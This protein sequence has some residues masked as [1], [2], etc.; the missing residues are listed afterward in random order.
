VLGGRTSANDLARLADLA[1]E[2]GSGRIRTTNTQSI[3]LLD[4][5]EANLAPLRDELN[6]ARFNY[7][8]SWSRRGIIAC[9][10]IQFCKLAVAE[11]KNRAAELNDYLENSVALDG[12]VRISV[13]GCPNSCGQH[14]ICDVGL[15]GS[16]TT[17]NGVKRETF[18]VFLGGGVG[19]RETFGRRVGVRIPSE[20][21][22]ESIAR[23][24]THYRQAREE[25]ETFQDFC[26]RHSDKELAEYLAPPASPARQVE[27]SF[28][29][30]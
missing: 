28:A 24:L 10:G 23:L 25:G 16:V 5:P 12:P 7:E 8:P 2:Y 17:I 4:V 15:E 27:L 3:V 14:H 6:R 1:Q 19:E 21:M 22:A 29:A 20:E 26:L 13:T 9:T 11:T 30:D 18:Q